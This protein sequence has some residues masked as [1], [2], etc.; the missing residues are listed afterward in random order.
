MK[1]EI[2]QQ[3][4]EY[5]ERRFEELENLNPADNE[6][7]GAR[8][9]IVKEINTLVE[10]LQHEDVNEDNSRFNS[11]KIKNEITKIQKEYELNIKKLECEINKNKDNFNLEKEKIKNSYEI[12]NKKIENDLNKVD[13]E[14]RKINYE[15]ELNEKKIESEITKIQN[16][17][18][19]IDNDYEINKEKIQIEVRKNEDYSRLEDRK[20]NCTESKNKSDSILK[21]KELSMNMKRD[22]SLRSDRVIKVIVDGIT[23]IVPIV[24]YNV[25]MNKGFK[26]EETGTFTSTTFKNMINKFKPSK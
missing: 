11:E 19:K 26:F 10:I 20:I 24:F 3:I 12:D 25:W 4:E 7:Y 18:K 23:I 9:S 8:N 13:N 22:I 6:Y 2:K 5:V 16:E 1:R 17:I 14:L 15:Y 21:K